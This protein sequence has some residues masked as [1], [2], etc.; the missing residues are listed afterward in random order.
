M[1]LRASQ[2]RIIEEKYLIAFIFAGTLVHY[3]IMLIFIGIQKDSGFF[4]KCINDVENIEQA[5]ESFWGW[6]WHF[7][8]SAIFITIAVSGLFCDIKMLLFVKSQNKTQPAQLVPWKSVC[9]KNVDDDQKVPV[10]A[11]MISTISL[12][13]FLMLRILERVLSSSQVIEEYYFWMLSEFILLFAALNMPVMLMLTIKHKKN[14]LIVQLNQPP[15]KL[16]FHD[17]LIEMCGVS[18][19]LQFHEDFV[20]DDASQDLNNATTNQMLEIVEVHQESQNVG[21]SHTDLSST[22]SIVG[23]MNQT[24]IPN[25]IDEYQNRSRCND[26]QSLRNLDVPSDHEDPNEIVCIQR[27]TIIPD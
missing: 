13:L 1:A 20:S 5:I 8:L 19:P 15:Q 10:R 22:I 21:I 17:E 2:T 25:P 18:E 14:S 23:T 24:K 12:I 27:I 9:Q 16:Q 26:L 3:G 7:L 4:E 11:T 6:H